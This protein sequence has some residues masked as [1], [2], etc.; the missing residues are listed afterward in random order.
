VKLHHRRIGEGKAAAELPSAA[1]RAV[2][3]CQVGD[4]RGVLKLETKGSLDQFRRDLEQFA[5]CGHDVLIWQTAMARDIRG[6]AFR[7]G[8][9]AV[10]LISE[11]PY[12]RSPGQIRQPRS[13][14]RGR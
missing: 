12:R 3:S 2:V 4:N 13:S 11:N 10:Q 6:I 7:Y 5:R 8:A 9:D 1:L 14:R